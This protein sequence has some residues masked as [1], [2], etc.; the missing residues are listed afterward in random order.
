M[1][2]ISI[3]QAFGEI[4][5][6]QSTDRFISPPPPPPPPPQ[7]ISLRHI[8]DEYYEGGSF[9]SSST[10]SDA[11]NAADMVLAEI[12]KISPSRDESKE[13]AD[14]NSLLFTNHQVAE[15]DSETRE[16]S[17]NESMESIR[18]RLEEMI[19]SGDEI[20]SSDPMSSITECVLPSPNCQIGVCSTSSGTVPTTLGSHMSKCHLHLEGSN[21]SNLDQHAVASNTTRAVPQD[22]QDRNRIENSGCLPETLVSGSDAQSTIKKKPFLRRGTRKEPSAVHRF[23]KANQANTNKSLVSTKE[24][25]S[26]ELEHL[27]RMQEQQR[28]NLQK[29]IERRQRAREEIHRNTTKG[30]CKI[31][32]IDQD[33][34]KEHVVQHFTI[35]NDEEE[36][37]S[38]SDTSSDEA[39][40]VSDSFV[41]ESDDSGECEEGATSR[42]TTSCKRPMKSNKHARSSLKPIN[43]LKG[44]SKQKTS[45]DFQTPEMEEQWQVIKS[46][47]RRQ[48]S[49]L[50]AA[51]KDREEVR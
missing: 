28:E 31:Q 51:E 42:Q 26:K 44:S 21:E 33:Q 20:P 49:A 37:V 24:R 3:V 14:P 35:K 4:T 5:M 34:V 23:N 2:T 1:T 17:K 32:V 16:L 36:E 43:K 27:E 22:V 40:S 9:G 12:D 18:S 19:V 8:L 13:G 38:T 7:P 47:R 48:E 45:K 6:E 41:E 30:G 10:T 46:M 25:A 29:R 15:E 11:I 39:S 50:R